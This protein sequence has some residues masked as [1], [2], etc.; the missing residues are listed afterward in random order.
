MPEENG[1]THEPS[2]REL[3]AELDALRD[4]LTEKIG[5][6]ERVAAERDRRYEERF[7]SS[8]RAVDAALTAA[9]EQVQT[10]FA[11]A[12][13]AIAKAEQA[14]TIYNQTHNDLQRQM[15]EKEKLFAHKPE[16]DKEFERAAERTED[17]RRTFSDYQRLQAEEIRSLR[18][19][20]SAL[21]GAWAAMIGVSALVGTAA[22]FILHGLTGK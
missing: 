20:R 17:F 12:E 18:E 3:T 9:K 8:T 7:M 10:A 1:R 16:V 19:S 21:S 5:G 6:L 15:G 13:K 14:Q 4:L 2:L 22:G 11:S